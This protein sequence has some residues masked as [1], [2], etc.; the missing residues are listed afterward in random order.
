MSRISGDFKVRTRANKVLQYPPLMGG[1][2]MNLLSFNA[3]CLAVKVAS[4]KEL[5]GDR[6]L[7]VGGFGKFS[8]ILCHCHTT[9]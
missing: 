9:A 5:I 1:I 8:T 7:L 2:L 4:N 6:V 3:G